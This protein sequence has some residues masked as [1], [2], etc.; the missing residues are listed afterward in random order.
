[1]H[2]I[3]AHSIVS[4]TGVCYNAV[5]QLCNLFPEI[6]Q[7]ALKLCVAGVDIAELVFC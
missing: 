2:A 4:S 6:L 3:R 1:M 5:I 7:P